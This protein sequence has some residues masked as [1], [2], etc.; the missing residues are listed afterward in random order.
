M[1]LSV[2]LA[3]A[4]FVACGGDSPGAPARPPITTPPPAPP[5]PPAITWSVTGSVVE[6][7]SRAPIA[8]A[9]IAPSWQLAAVTSAAD[10]SY[11]LGAATFPPS[12]PFE[13]TVSAPGFV[14]RKLW[15]SWRVGPRTDISLDLIRDAAPFSM[16]FY[17]QM[18]RGSYDQEEAPWDLLRLNAAPRFYIKTV[19]EAGVPILPN[20]I[21]TIEEGIRKAVPAF[22]GGRFS[23]TVETGAAVRPQAAGWIN[24]DILSDPG[25]GTACGRAFVGADPGHITLYYDVR[26]CGCGSERIAAHTVAHEVAHALGFFHVGDRNSVL[27]PILPGSCPV[28]APSVLEL[29]H[30]T[31]AYSRAR[32]NT[33]PDN[34]PSTGP[35]STTGGLS[36]RR[37]LIKN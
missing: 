13:V 6:T 19:D 11:D 2:A 9:A 36:G 1:F 37:I 3:C 30:A 22:T 14:T 10:G 4:A 29:H 21:V 35:M 16:E 8:G 17:Q 31:I 5:A 23:A 33:E 26:G 7:A 34:D 28:P 24:V 20:V 12:T 32:G 27:Y 18:V 25:D 15:L